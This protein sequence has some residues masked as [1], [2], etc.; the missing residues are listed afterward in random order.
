MRIRGKEP[1]PC[2]YDP[3][4]IVNSCD[5]VLV[6]RERVSPARRREGIA[7]SSID[8]SVSVVLLVS[9]DPPTHELL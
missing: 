6:E 7:G 2:L 9:M 5:A 8:D 1:R 3:A 4:R